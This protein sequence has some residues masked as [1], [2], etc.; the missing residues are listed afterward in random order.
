MSRNKELLN[1]Y[2]QRKFRIGVFQL[3]NTVNGKIFLGSGTNVDALWNRHRSELNFGNHR[4]EALQADWKA[5]GEGA[6]VFE[7]LSE[8]EQKDD[9]GTDYAREVKELEQ[10]F[11]SELKPWGERGYHNPPRA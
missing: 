4:N 5:A 11:F 6:F 10:L 9:T 7:V 1:D 8:I 2:K 3:R